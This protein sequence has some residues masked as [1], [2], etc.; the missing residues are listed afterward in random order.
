MSS[1]CL[2]F[3]NMLSTSNIFSSF[4]PFS[5][6]YATLDPYFNII[7]L[8]QKVAFSFR[9]NLFLIL[10]TPIFQIHNSRYPPIVAE[11]LK[12]ANAPLGL[13]VVTFDRNLESDRITHNSAID[14]KEAVD[15]AAPHDCVDVESNDPLYILYTSGTTGKKL[16]TPF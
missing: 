6:S 8:G 13:P 5:I 15:K 14:W 3:I 10:W 7:I 11:A 9:S 4:A 16:I 12:L 1:F 2:H